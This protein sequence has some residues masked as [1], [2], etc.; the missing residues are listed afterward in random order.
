MI[1][2]L[3]V[4]EQMDCRRFHEH[5]QVLS[6]GR[7]G[8]QSALRYRRR[9]IARNQ[10]LSHTDHDLYSRMLRS[11]YK[12]MARVRFFTVEQRRSDGNRRAFLIDVLNVRFVRRICSALL[13]FSTCWHVFFQY[14]LCVVHLLE[15]CIH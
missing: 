2:D 1:F 15:H 8:R 14:L 6:G 5:G 10:F 13:T 4:S 3:F 7:G 11:P 9:P 12:Q